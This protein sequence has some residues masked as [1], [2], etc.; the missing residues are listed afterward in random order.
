MLFTSCE[1]V[2]E[3]C[4][5]LHWIKL[6]FDFV[7]M[8]VFAEVILNICFYHSFIYQENTVKNKH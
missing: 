2:T 5:T 4:I 7:D 8:S 6:L 3:L 1:M